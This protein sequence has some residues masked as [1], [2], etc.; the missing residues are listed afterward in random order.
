VA[1]GDGAGALQLLLPPFGGQHEKCIQGA[2]RKNVFYISRLLGAT[3]LYCRLHVIYKEMSLTDV[4]FKVLDSLSLVFLKNRSYQKWHRINSTP[5]IFYIKNNNQISKF[6]KELADS[7]VAKHAAWRF[8]PCKLL[9]TWY[10]FQNF[11]REHLVLGAAIQTWLRPP[12]LDCGHPNLIAA[13]SVR[14]RP[15]QLDCGFLSWLRPPLLDC[16]HPT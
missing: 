16:S 4:A 10:N 13:I 15:P 14:L 1:R 6:F 2:K 12:K 8:F 9:S 7:N 11:P 3:V 5:V